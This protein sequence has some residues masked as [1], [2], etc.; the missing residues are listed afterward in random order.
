MELRTEP[1]PAAGTP[2]GF[3]PLRPLGGLQG[4]ARITLA[5]HEQTGQ[6]VAIK[7]VALSTLNQADEIAR[8]EREIA[9]LTVLRHPQIPR[10]LDTHVRRLDGRIVIHLIQ[11]YVDG[12]TLLQLLQAGFA[13]RPAD[14][15]ATLLGTLAPLACLHD[16][17]PPILH[18]DIKPSNIVVRP[19]G[20][21]VLI[22]F[23]AVHDA[24]VPSPLT[25]NAVVGTFGY[26]P[27][28]QFEGHASR[29]SD[30]HALG[31]TALHL[32][33]GR[34]PARF[35]LLDGVP[36]FAPAVAHTPALGSI[37]RKLLDPDPAA[38]FPDAHALRRTLEDW[39][40]EHAPGTPPTLD[41][42]RVAEHRFVAE[43]QHYQPNTGLRQ[44]LSSNDR[45]AVSPA[46]STPLPS[47]TPLSPASPR[48]ADDSPPRQDTGP[49]VS[50][51][52]ANHNGDS[53][54]WRTID[55]QSAPGRPWAV[56][57]PASGAYPTADGLPGS[58]DA[59]GWIDTG[60]GR[61]LTE[62]RF[63]P[64]APPGLQRSDASRTNP[65]LRGAHRALL[66]L[67]DDSRPTAR[68]RDTSPGLGPSEFDALDEALDQFRPPSSR[69]SPGGGRPADDNPATTG[70][71]LELAPAHRALTVPDED[72]SRT[73]S[74][75]GSMAAIVAPD[76]PAPTGLGK[77]TT[78]HSGSMAAIMVP[79]D[80]E[81]T[82]VMLEAPEDTT[83]TW[84]TAPFRSRP[85]AS[86]DARTGRTPAEVRADTDHG[87]DPDAD[88]SELPAA[89]G[90]DTVAAQTW[91]PVDLFAEDDNEA[92]AALV[93]AAFQSV[94]APEGEPLDPPRAAT[95][96][97]EPAD[98]E[99]AP[100]RPEPRAADGRA[101][102]ELPAPERPGGSG[103]V[104]VVH[105]EPTDPIARQ[106]TGSLRAVR[107]KRAATLT[108]RLDDGVAPPADPAPATDPAESAA[109][110]PLASGKTV[111]DPNDPTGPTVAV[112]DDQVEERTGVHPAAPVH[113][114][115]GR[116]PFV[117]L[118]P[119]ADPAD[120]PFPGEPVAPHA[121]TDGLDESATATTLAEAPE[122]TDAPAETQT[123]DTSGTTA[124]EEQP[125]E[126]GPSADAAS[127][128]AEAGPGD[129]EPGSADAHESTTEVPAAPE[130]LDVGDPEAD[131]PDA[132]PSPPQQS[133]ER[134]LYDPSGAFVAFGP[135]VDPRVRRRREVARWYEPVLPGGQ[136][137]ATTGLALEIAGVLLALGAVLFALGSIPIWILA[138]GAVLL[139]YGAILTLSPRW[140]A[141]RA[142]GRRARTAIAPV[143]QVLA[144][145]RRVLWTGNV[146]WWAEYTFE[147]PEEWSSSGR[148]R[149]RSGAVARRLYQAPERTRVRYDLEDPDG[150]STL[151]VDAAGPDLVE[152]PNQRGRRNGRD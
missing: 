79:R 28:E 12:P 125:E 123:T 22:D 130:P 131:A 105:V 88:T 78:S 21:C 35:E 73:T 69:T 140:G 111:A 148:I 102:S 17:E 143:H 25:D 33:T 38:R 149:L 91:R 80:A 97:S 104:A 108:L 86:G 63:D 93:D 66:D 58:A 119:A 67:A 54:F 106:T 13:F 101:L 37:L 32:L 29:A 71:G 82:E 56:S 6:R 52:D 127:V 14:V 46:A 107:P 83:G 147:T 95:A 142:P 47:V 7:T 16:R 4:H 2:P 51:T 139:I 133:G 128:Q 112:R 134:E 87:I 18:R 41:P 100:E 62:E 50:T 39:V 36:Q 60:G 10:L 77:R 141:T 57:T 117:G 129:G 11:E 64:H 113:T 44:P 90:P 9:T 70:R 23:G 124:A 126:H 92:A 136:G 45:P 152:S 145:E 103:P 121:A 99:P 115:S 81:T 3:R 48:P 24:A 122:G 15:V 27:P 98:F 116:A 151:L 19:D 89:D 26:M 138:V 109:P 43:L 65:G 55:S 20:S 1:D 61:A 59:Q 137:A 30:L 110:E 114:A 76:E 135:P 40:R 31:A 84:P 72:N 144:V 42:S 34:E 85:P 94:I 74:Y 146:E 75:S 132:Q 49:V 96:D 5:E 53:G 118:E 150:L 8:C 68:D 120:E